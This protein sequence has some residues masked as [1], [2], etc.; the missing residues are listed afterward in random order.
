MSKEKSKS[1]KKIK[2]TCKYT[3]RAISWKNQI[4]VFGKGFGENL[5]EERFSPI[6]NYKLLYEH[7]I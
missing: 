1:A 6:N 2:K 4:K 7:R 3:G 5:S